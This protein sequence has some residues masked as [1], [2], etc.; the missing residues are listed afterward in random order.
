MALRELTH[1]E[2]LRLSELFICFVQVIVCFLANISVID[3]FILSTLL[4]FHRSGPSCLLKVKKRTGTRKHRRNFSFWKK[5]ERE[6]QRERLVTCDRKWRQI[7]W[8][9]SFLTWMTIKSFFNSDKIVILREEKWE[10]ETGDFFGYQMTGKLFPCLC[11]MLLKV[12]FCNH[13]ILSYL[14]VLKE[15]SATEI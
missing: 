5:E 9:W 3:I 1:S 12:S 10:D 13:K 14:F 6:R 8:H 4:R 15:E 11:F 2:R 7:Q